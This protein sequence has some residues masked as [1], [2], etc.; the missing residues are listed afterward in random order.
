MQIIEIEGLLKN[1]KTVRNFVDAIKS[2][3]KL[4]N[5]EEKLQLLNERLQKD[6][7]HALIEFN[8]K[9]LEKLDKILNELLF[10]INDS[11]IDLNDFKNIFLSGTDACK[12][13]GIP[14][15]M[16]AVFISNLVDVKLKS[17]ILLYAVGICGDI[18]ASKSDIALLSDKDID[19]LCSDRYQK[20]Q[21]SIEP[22][23]QLVNRR[24]IQN[25]C[26]TLISFKKELNVSYPILSNN[27]Q[28]NVKSDI[29]KNLLAIFKIEPKNIQTKKLSSEYLESEHNL[30]IK[31]LT[32]PEIAIEKIIKL[33]SE[34]NLETELESQLIS[35]LYATFERLNLSKQIE[36]LN[37]LFKKRNNFVVESD[38]SLLCI[39]DKEISATTLES[40]Y[41][42]PF[43]NFAKSSL[44]LKEKENGE[45]N[46]TERGNV[47]HEVLKIFI[48]RLDEVSDKTSCD[49]L[50]D[51][52][53][54]GIIAEQKYQVLTSKPKYVHLFNNLKQEARNVAYKLYLSSKKTLFKPVLLEEP[55]G[56]K[57]KIKGI[58][59]ETKVGTYKVKGKVDRVDEYD[60][61]IRIIDYKSGDFSA[62][63][64]LFYVG[65]KLQLYLYMNAFLTDGRKPAGAYYSPIDMQFSSDS[66]DK[67]E[68]NGKTVDDKQIID[69]TDIDAITSKHSS[70]FNA[71]T[72]DGKINKSP[73]LSEEEFNDYLKYSKL[74]SINA[75]NE[76]STGFI[77]P[78]PYDD[79]CVYCKFNGMCG[80]CVNEDD[81]VR[82]VG[83]IKKGVIPNAVKNASKKEQD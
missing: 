48:N 5:I 56:E 10:V 71:Y 19:K 49:K 29:V 57:C 61:R 65:K 69:A 81:K 68:L 33:I 24:E 37:N 76:I 26:T 41:S 59:L 8:D 47:L 60:N 39:R 28:I 16:D 75:I 35:L 6:D 15:Y 32:S 7:E 46:T 23:I 80:F 1:A 70:I 13:S 9:V 53:F 11:P 77:E 36:I 72:K 54:D 45:I 50:V 40:Y 82:K 62:S 20:Y 27:G 55:F 38:N 63:N 73:L 83:A 64:S 12:V 17:P 58:P 51:E 44:K 3:L 25:V 34:N 79:S 30:I 2:I 74:I 22:K 21:V 18:P 14:L 43:A 4:I 52:I 78:T 42:C 31:S 67:L 66:K